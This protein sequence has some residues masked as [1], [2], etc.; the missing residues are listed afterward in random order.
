MKL[1]VIVVDP[2]PTIVRAPVPATIVATA[3]LLEAHVTVGL[4]GVPSEEVASALKPGSVCP[5]GKFSGIVG[6]AGVT[7]NA[8]TTAAVTVSVAGFETVVAVVPAGNA[9]GTVAATVADVE[10][11]RPKTCP[12]ERGFF[13][14]FA[15]VATAAAL[16]AHATTEVTSGDVPSE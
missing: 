14:V 5:V 10:A 12:G 15:K 11:V 6:L 2:T 4:P 1:A 9:Q 3:R 16:Q 13:F 8:V 7:V